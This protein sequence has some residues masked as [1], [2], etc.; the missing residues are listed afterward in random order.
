LQALPVYEQILDMPYPLLKLDI[1]LVDD[2]D[3]GVLETSW[4]RL[5]VPISS[6]PRSKVALGP[7][8]GIIGRLGRRNRRT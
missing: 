7:D 4:V 5:A 1:L 3:D 8:R 2:F 6:S